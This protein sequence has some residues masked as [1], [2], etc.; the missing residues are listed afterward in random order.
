MFDAGEERDFLITVGVTS[1]VDNLRKSP[2]YIS[3]YPTLVLT[4]T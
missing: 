4:S 3:S 1:M 2:G